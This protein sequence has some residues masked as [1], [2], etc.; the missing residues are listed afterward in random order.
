MEAETATW[1]AERIAELY[2]VGNTWL[3]RVHP[4]TKL[5]A[6]LPL[7][8]AGFVGDTVRVPGALLIAAALTLL[9]SRLGIVVLKSLRLLAP[10]TI[11]LFVIHGVVRPY[12]SEPIAAWGP[13]SINA[14]GLALAGTTAARLAVLVKP[15]SAP[16]STG[17]PQVLA[18]PHKQTGGCPKQ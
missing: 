3:H 6:V 16:E 14:E 11:A 10:M 9:L 17:N 4:L 18:P 13:I 8:V 2:E 15:V 1:S 5:A 12:E 7:S